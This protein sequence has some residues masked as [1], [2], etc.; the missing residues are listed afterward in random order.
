MACRTSGT[1]HAVWET[2]LLDYEI[3]AREREKYGCNCDVAAELTRHGR[4][5]HL[6]AKPREPPRAPRGTARTALSWDAE[7]AKRMLMN[8][9]DPAN[10]VDWQHLVVYGGSGRAVRNWHEYPQGRCARSTRSA[11][12]KH[13]ACNP[14]ARFTSPAPTPA[15]PA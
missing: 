6:A 4:P 11:K 3:A 8:N 7:A 2:P 10:A 9:L 15:R 14:A 1:H 13:C 5:L 12:T